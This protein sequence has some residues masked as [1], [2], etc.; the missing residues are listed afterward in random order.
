MSWEI[1]LPLMFSERNHI[2]FMLILLYTFGT[3][4]QWSYMGL[5]DFFF[6]GI[7]LQIKCFDGYRT[8]YLGWVLRVYSFW[9]IDLFL[10]NCQIYEYKIGYIVF[11]II[12]LMAVESKWYPLFNSWYWRF[13][14][15]LFLSLSV[16]LEACQFYWFF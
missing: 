16:L 13:V 8:L 4:L 9:E 1:F 14:S 5:T 2:T 10:L 3:I 15:S 6:R 11:I 7:I 12:F